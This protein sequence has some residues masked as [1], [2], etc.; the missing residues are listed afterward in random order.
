MDRVEAHQHGYESGK[1]VCASTSISKMAG[2]CQA[3][4]EEVVYNDKHWDLT[5]T[6]IFAL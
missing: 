3:R 1:G 6:Y 5:D 4:E 2:Q